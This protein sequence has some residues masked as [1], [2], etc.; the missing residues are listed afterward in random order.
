MHTLG[1][2]LLAPTLP[3]YLLSILQEVTYVTS[4]RN[5]FPG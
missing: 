4:S 3:A 2:V 1:L 5:T